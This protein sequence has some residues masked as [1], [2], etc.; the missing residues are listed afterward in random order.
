MK[1]KTSR[2]FLFSIVILLAGASLAAQKLDIAKLE[3]LKPRSIGPAAMSGRVTALAVDP[4]DHE[5]IYVGT[6]SGGLWKSSGGG[7]TWEPIFDDQGSASIGAVAVDPINP[8][9]IWVGTGEGNPRNSQSV[10][11]GIY[12]SLDGGKTWKN[13]GLKESEHIHRILVHP[14]DSRTVYAAAPGPSWS[15]G[16]ERGVFKTTDGGKTWE[17]VLYENPRTGA[18]DLVMDPSNPDKL[19]A[20]MWEHRRTPWDFKSGGPASGIHVSHDGGETWERRSSKDGLP[21]G[22][23]GRIGL[24]IAPSNPKIVYALIESK[25][26]ALYRS[27]D[28]GFRWRKT[29]DDPSIGNRPFYYSDIRVDPLNENRVYSLHSTVTYSEDGGRTFETLIPFSRIHPDHHAMWIDPKDPAYLIEGNDGGLA[30]SRDRGRTWRFVGNLPLGQFYHISVDM[31]TPYNVYGGLQD[32]GTFMGPSQ[33]WERGFAGAGSILN[34]HWQMVGFGD[35]FNALADLSDERYVYGMSQGG[36]LYRYDRVTGSNVLI[37]PPA[38]EG[39]KLRFNWNAALAADP[40]EPGTIY[41]GSQF[42][43]KSTNRGDE[44]RIISG[45]LTTNDPEKQKQLD[46]GGLTYDVTNAENHTTIVALAASPVKQGVLWA[47]TDDGN[48]QV[49]RDGG[50]SW[51]NVA[52]NI[53]G[54]PSGTWVPHIEASKFREGGAYVVFDDHRRGNWTP[55][56]YKTTDFGESWESLSTDTLRG[57]VYVIEQDPRVENLLFLGTEFHLY[58]SLDGGGSWTQW[59]HGYPTVPTR[60]LEVHPREPDLVI[61]TFGRAIYI[62]DDIT[63]LRTLAREGAQILDLP[64]RLFELAPAIQA[65]QGWP[66]GELVPGDSGFRGENRPP[67]VIV[68]YVYNPAEGAEGEDGGDGK[69][70]DE[71]GSEAKKKTEVI[72]EVLRGDEV[73]RTLKG[74]A[75]P[76]LNRVSWSMDRGRPRGFSREAP[77]E[78]AAEPGNIPVL[79]GTYQVRVRA[80]EEPDTQCVEVLGDPRLSMSRGD[81]E[82][83]QRLTDRYLAVLEQGEKI[84]RRL[85]EA[86]QTMDRVEALIKDRKDEKLAALREQ[87]KSTG[88]AWKKLQD[89]LFPEPV[90]GIRLDPTL[91]TAQVNNAS[92]YLNGFWL[93]PSQT[94]Q[95]VMQQVEQAVEAFSKDV[96]NFF[97]GEFKDFG[98]AVKNADVSIVE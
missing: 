63:P 83:Y 50:G 21:A 37:K 97:Q 17:R 56:V 51:S 88:L 80:G 1:F 71:P 9:V 81:L 85:R 18:A 54:V 76:G 41:Y 45:D 49:T 57:F 14:R 8:D 98:R 4:R 62:L 69:N 79:P 86:K 31:Q 82:A 48:V 40:L 24:A 59:Q 91:L 2:R 13:L 89:R 70:G 78:D 23:L 38:P 34:R 55:Y 61:G 28:G 30:I 10:G 22:E 46:S 44:W 90:Q 20:A 96:E 67:G 84:S 73:I 68:N 87:T 52:S 11:D 27:D 93:A 3:A 16:E 12:K 94:A 35:G 95:T 15:D 19:I 72:V 47:G 60:D 64:L 36:Y 53:P 7:V 66:A 33:V 5:V 75:K 92:G 32:N 29:S 6:A 42:V 43:H 77:P 74:T 25:K 58:F 39:V 26:N 65:V